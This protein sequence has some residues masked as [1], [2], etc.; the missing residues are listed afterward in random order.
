M[1]PTT[2]QKTRSTEVMELLVQHIIHRLKSGERDPGIS[3]LWVTNNK[4]GEGFYMMNINHEDSIYPIALLVESNLLMSEYT[5]H[6]PGFEKTPTNMDKASIVDVKGGL[7][8]VEP[9]NGTDFTLE[10]LQKIVGG[11]IQMIKTKD[12]RTMVINEEGKLNN[13]PVNSVATE[14]YEHGESDPVVG[15]VLICPPRMIK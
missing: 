2:E 11:Y 13:L 7:N 6:H 12:G 14:R 5:V 4:T 1:E 15:T 8:L 3:A 9:A 10:E